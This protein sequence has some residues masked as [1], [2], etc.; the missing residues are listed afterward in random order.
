MIPVI[1]VIIH[2]AILAEKSTLIDVSYSIT[3][4]ECKSVQYYRSWFGGTGKQVTYQQSSGF[5]I[6]S[7]NVLPRPG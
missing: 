1:I 3:V 7:R 5:R 6:E 4:D 2:R